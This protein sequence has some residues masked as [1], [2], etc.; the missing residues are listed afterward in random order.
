LI[1]LVE[2]ILLPES[3]E[4]EPAPEPPEKINVDGPGSPD[5]DLLGLEDLFREE[6]HKASGS[7]LTEQDIDRIADRVIQRVSSQ[8]IESIAW[9]IVPDITERIVREELKRIR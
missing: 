1:E 2:S 9:D 4:V 7:A 5:E 8:A 6:A 3:E